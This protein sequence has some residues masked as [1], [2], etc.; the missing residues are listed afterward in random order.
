MKK[1]I[2]YFLIL[3]LFPILIFSQEKH[4]SLKFDARVDF[5]YFHFM[6]SDEA[7]DK[8]GFAGKYLNVMLDGRINDKVEYH[9]RQ[10]L[11]R[12]N[13]LT[14]FFTATDWAY[15]DYHLNDNFTLSAGKQVVAIGGFEYDY[16]PID[17]FFWSDFWA[18]IP[19]YQLGVSIAGKD[20]SGRNTL[21]FQFANSPFSKVVYES[22]YSYNLLWKGNFGW[23]KT[24]YSVNMIEYEQGDFI[25]Y[26]ALGNQFVV[27]GFTLDL[28]YTNRYHGKQESFFS[29]FSIVA[30]AKYSIND[31]WNVFVKGGYDQNKSQKPSTP[32][33]D[34][35]DVCVVPGTEYAFCGGGFEFFP[36]NNSRDLRV[37]AFCAGNNTASQP[38]NFNV[39]ITWKMK[40]LD[41][42][43]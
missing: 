37:H 35:W 2:L 4:V 12:T 24:L 8:S 6:D 14:E 41:K 22:L 17:V 16:A 11:N 15:I 29:D 13:S 25:N 31:K 23:F 27:G 18:N 1:R 38:V 19:C 34:Y 30:N 32:V 3:T 9:W 5:D 26:I 28:D 39:G 20:N 33:S 10:R 21:L 36:L 40:V 43:Y 7:D 42:Q